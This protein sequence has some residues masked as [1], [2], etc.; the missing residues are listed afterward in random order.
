MS[1]YT[2]VYT[3]SAAAD[4]GKLDTLSKKRLGKKI[5]EWRQDPVSKSRKLTNSKIGGY[6][7]RVGDYRVVFDVIGLKV[8]ILR[9]GHRKEIC[10]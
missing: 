9:V 5:I 6:R 3:K 1:V 4:I 7:Y 2:L 8:I 10:R